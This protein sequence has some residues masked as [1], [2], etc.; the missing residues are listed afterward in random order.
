MRGEGGMW[1]FATA[2]FLVL[3]FFLYRHPR[4]TLKV[5]GVVVALILGGVG[6]IAYNDSTSKSTYM[7]TESRR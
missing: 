6:I 3:V 2:V 1:V 7:L 4:T 5:L